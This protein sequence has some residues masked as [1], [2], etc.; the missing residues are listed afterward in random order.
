MN[1]IRTQAARLVPAVALV[2]FVVVGI[3]AHGTDLIR[4]VAGAVAVLAMT[5]FRTGRPAWALIA[6][7]VL[8]TVAVAVICDGSSGN[9]GWFASITIVRL[10]GLERWTSR[11]GHRVPDRDRR[12]G[13]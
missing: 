13:L 9:P 1:L 12:A 6:P 8:S 2:T 3:I 4:I 10:D 11:V 5:G 7:A